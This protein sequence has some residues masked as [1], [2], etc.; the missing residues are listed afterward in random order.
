MNDTTEGEDIPC[1]TCGTFYKHT[2]DCEEMKRKG[3]TAPVVDA[4]NKLERKEKLINNA[5]TS[6]T[7]AVYD[8]GNGKKLN[9]QQFQYLML[10][11]KEV[12]G[13]DLKSY[14]ELVEHFEEEAKIIFS[15][16]RIN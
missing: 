13:S 14:E 12:L 11:L 3:E 5:I 8:V 15:D 4:W 1:M 2:E 16:E 6:L 9:T 7:G 10:S